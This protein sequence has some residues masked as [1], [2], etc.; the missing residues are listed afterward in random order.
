VAAQEIIAGNM[1]GEEAGEQNAG[2]A[3]QWRDLNPDLVENY[4]KYAEGLA[5]S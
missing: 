3:Q 4:Q 1:T 5:A 2:I